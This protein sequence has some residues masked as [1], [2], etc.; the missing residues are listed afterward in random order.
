MR[1]QDKEGVVKNENKNKK[2][3]PYICRMI[4]SS[5]RVITFISHLIPTSTLR[6]QILISPHSKEDSKLQAKWPEKGHPAIK[7]HSLQ[8]PNLQPEWSVSCV[9]R[10]A[11][12]GHG[13]MVAS[14]SWFEYESHRSSDPLLAWWEEETSFTVFC[15]NDHSFSGD[16]HPSIFFQCGPSNQSAWDDI[17]KAILA[18]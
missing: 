18:P 1:R 9:T 8:T 17:K 5:Q 10:Q 7:W 15:D 12:C 13:K 11:S 4:Y 3:H 14:Q 2:K 6:G 16:S